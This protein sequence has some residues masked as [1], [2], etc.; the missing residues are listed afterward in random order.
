MQTITLTTHQN[1]WS[2]TQQFDMDVEYAI[3]ANLIVVMYFPAFELAPTVQDSGA[4]FFIP[5]QLQTTDPTTLAITVRA[6]G[7]QESG[8]ST[9]FMNDLSF[10]PLGGGFPVGTGMSGWDA[11]TYCYLLR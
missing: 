8:E 3:I 4:F 5:T 10:G 9:I 6:D 1:P 2:T 11:G 7:A